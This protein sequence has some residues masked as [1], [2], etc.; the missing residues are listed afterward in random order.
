MTLWFMMI[1]AT[2]Q[3]RV[4]PTVLW[5]R[6]WDFNFWWRGRRRCSG[7]P[8]PIPNH[9]DHLLIDQALGLQMKLERRFVADSSYPSQLDFTGRA[10]PD[11]HRGGVTPGGKLRYL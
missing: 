8:K 7:A 5:R 11:S 6:P 1:H 9:P 2:L 3:R 10:Y 4:E